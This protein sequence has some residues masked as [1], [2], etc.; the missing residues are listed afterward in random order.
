MGEKKEIEQAQARLDA[1]ELGRLA[2]Q[3]E[4]KSRR[5]EGEEAQLRIKRA[6]FYAAW[7]FDG[8]PEDSKPQAAEFGLEPSKVTLSL[9]RPSPVSGAVQKEEKDN[10]RF[11]KR[12][13][14]GR[15]T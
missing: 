2:G 9:D 10:G 1:I 3:L 15:R 11:P 4:A 13:V 5:E 12:K 14:G 6:M 7:T 8:R